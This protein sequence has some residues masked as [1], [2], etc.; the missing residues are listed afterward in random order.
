MTI[1]KA[2]DGLLWVAYRKGTNVMVSHSTNSGGAF[3]ATPF[4]IP[5]M[6]NPVTTDDMTAISTVGTN[7]VGVLW[8]NQTA[9]EEAFYF[10]AHKDGD[11]DGTWT[12]R[13]TAFGGSGTLSADGHI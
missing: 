6:G 2:P 10:A 1:T 11:A 13:E 9:G 3:W 4:V 7:G 5:G 8:S 12:A